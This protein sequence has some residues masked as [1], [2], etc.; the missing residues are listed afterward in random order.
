MHGTFSRYLRRVARET[1]FLEWNGDRPLAP[2]YLVLVTDG[3][4]NNRTLTWYEAMATR[5]QAI[6]IMAVSHQLENLHV[7]CCSVAF[8]SIERG[9]VY[10]SLHFV[11]Y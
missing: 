8:Q 6:T 2:N 9:E 1:M 5:A 4:S 11:R 7:I 10:D 3:R